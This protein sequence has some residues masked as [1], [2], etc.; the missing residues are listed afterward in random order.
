MKTF[1]IID[2]WDIFFESVYKNDLQGVNYSLSRGCDI[3]FIDYDQRS[4]LHI[5]VAENNL[6][7]V[8]ILIDRGINTE[9]ID[10]WGKK[11]SEE[12]NITEDIKQLF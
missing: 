1:S 10:R 3:N 7:M 5:A 11:P 6:D 2:F 9:I 4:A 8:K 12:S